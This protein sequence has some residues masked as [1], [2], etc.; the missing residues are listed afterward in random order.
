MGLNLRLSY[1]QGNDTEILYEA[2]GRCAFDYVR[3]WVE[4]KGENLEFYGKDIQLKEEDVKILIC[5][6]VR[7]YLDDYSSCNDIF[8]DCLRDSPT[9]FYIGLL[10]RLLM[11]KAIDNYNDYYLECDW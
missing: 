10:Q 2:E 6:A 5:R 3:K 4:S 11:I 8:T 1:K 7:Q 9:W